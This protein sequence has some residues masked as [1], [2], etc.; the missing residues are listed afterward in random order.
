MCILD[1][2]YDFNGQ[3]IVQDPRIVDSCLFLDI[4]PR[5]DLSYSDFSHMITDIAAALKGVSF[6]AS[7]SEPVVF[8]FG[9]V[10]D[11]WKNM[12]HIWINNW[13]EWDPATDKFKLPAH[14]RDGIGIC[15]S[16]YK[17]EPMYYQDYEYHEIKKVDIPVETL[18][19]IASAMDKY[20]VFLDTSMF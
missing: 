1:I 18:T 19:K 6:H 12:I 9:P 3:M 15:L 17:Y 5:K 13:L 7:W 10:V 14:P 2:P 16:Q 4:F 20:S 11:G 8:L